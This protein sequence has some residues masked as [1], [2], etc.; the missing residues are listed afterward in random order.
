MVMG[1]RLLRGLPE[2]G[3]VT[4]KSFFRKT[5]SYGYSTLFRILFPVNIYDPQIGFKIYS[6]AA[7]D[8]IIESIRLP[9]DGLK[10]SEIVLRF[11]G[12]GYRIKE[13]PIN[14]A[15]DEDS[16]CVPKKFPI[17]IIYIIFINL[18]CMYSILKKDYKSGIV[19]RK[20]TRF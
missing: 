7:F 14:Y 4:G 18:F 13:C 6:K 17:K 5:L 8:S 11:F 3:S 15:H 16:R 19:K 9:H 20:C 2:I 12:G 10:S 1:S